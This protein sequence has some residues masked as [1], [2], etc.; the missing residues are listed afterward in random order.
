MKVDSEAAIISVIN[1][2]LPD[3][4]IPAVIFILITACRDK[5]KILILGWNTRK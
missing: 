3:S 2:V 4:V 5:Y 1:K